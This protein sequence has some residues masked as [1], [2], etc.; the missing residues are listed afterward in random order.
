MAFCAA[1]TSN[2]ETGANESTTGGTNEGKVKANPDVSR[3]SRLVRSGA[4]EGGKR[5]ARKGGLP[6]P[7]EVWSRR[8]GGAKVTRNFAELR[9]PEAGNAELDSGG[10]LRARKEGRDNMNQETVQVC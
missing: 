5:A 10:E 2:A 1:S 4:L 9:V 8:G 7:K 3:K 6:T